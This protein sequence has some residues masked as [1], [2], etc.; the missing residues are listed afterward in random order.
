MPWVK[1]SFPKPFVAFPGLDAFLCCALRRNWDVHGWGQDVLG[2]IPPVRD[3]CIL[4]VLS[5]PQIRC[6]MENCLSLFFR[7]ANFSKYH[8]VAINKQCVF[9]WI[10]PWLTT[11]ERIL[12]TPKTE[13][14][15]GGLQ[16]GFPLSF[17][18]VFIL[19]LY[20]GVFCL[21]M[22]YTNAPGS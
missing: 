13:L 14:G 6:Y 3:T 9:A 1:I 4:F 5:L 10:L 19:I 2:S 11:E 21:H 17:K 16:S 12:W 7:S 22:H 20:E 15:W 18:N 8:Q